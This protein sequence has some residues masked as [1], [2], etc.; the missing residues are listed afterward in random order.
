MIEWL[1][2]NGLR[3]DEVFAYAVEKSLVSDTQTLADW[4]LDKVGTSKLA[5]QQLAN[6]IRGQGSDLGPQEGEAWR[7]FPMPF[8]K[9]AGT[10]LE[11]LDKKYL[12]GL[13]AN[14]EVETEYNGNAKKPETIEKDK[15]FR[16]M[17]DDA[18][19]HYEFEKKD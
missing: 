12:Y 19:V 2:S 14:Y 9:N 5:W 17:L 1:L 8:G 13:W 18:G 11:D 15:L 7:E 6:D 10:K 16:S 3:E 4:P